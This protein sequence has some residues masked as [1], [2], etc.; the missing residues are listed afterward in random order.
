MPNELRR[1]ERALLSVSDKS[2][3]IDFA[4][5]LHR[6]G[7]VMRRACWFLTLKGRLVSQDLSLGRIEKPELLKKILLDPA[8]RPDEPQQPE[9]PWEEAR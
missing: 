4:R 3:L 9:L 1:V 2:G 7:I 6:L 5:A 8:F